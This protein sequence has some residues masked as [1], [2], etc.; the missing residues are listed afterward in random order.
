MPQT[1][2][3][4]AASIDE[5]NMS[6]STI[7]PTA[8]IMALSFFVAALLVAI[9]VNNVAGLRISLCCFVLGL[10]VVTFARIVGGDK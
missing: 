2:A 3:H 9:V 1:S 5:D 8:L 4:V 10:A 7:S 6:K